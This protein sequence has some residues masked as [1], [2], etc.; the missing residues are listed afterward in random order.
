MFTKFAS[1]CAASALFLMAS[2]PVL[3]SAS[4]QST[5]CVTSERPKYCDCNVVNSETTALY[6]EKLC[7]DQ[8]SRE[9]SKSRHN[10]WGVPQN[11][12][13]SINERLLIQ[14][15][16]VINH[17]ADLRI[18]I[19]VSY[20]LT[21]DD[22]DASL[23]RR[24]CFRR[25]VRLSP[26]DGARC[27]DYDEPFG[28]QPRYDR[29]HLVPSLDMVRSEVAMVNTYMFSNIAPQHGEFNRFNGGI[30]EHLEKRV[31]DWARAKGAIYVIAGTIFDQDGDGL[32]D[33]DTEASFLPTTTGAR[34][35]I[36]THFFKIV[37]Y[38][39]ERGSIDSLAF[40]L[41]HVDQ[42]VPAN[43]RDAL[44]ED[45]LKSICEIETRTGVTFLPTLTQNNPEWAYTVKSKVASSLWP[46]T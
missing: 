5:E 27:G 15:H 22:L 23:D 4:A 44:L 31:R 11:S 12:K 26:D 20:R 17:D 37:L 46:S 9:V 34:V 16:Y 36:P 2:A 28:T 32:R 40:V 41:E 29:G 43:E 45:S 7:L 30:W 14:K 39:E 42:R 3:F 18:P 25:D 1:Q 19:W 33:A 13:S 35:A 10:P 6:D 24:G 21:K 8:R 38:A